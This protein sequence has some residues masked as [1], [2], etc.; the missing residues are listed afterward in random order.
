MIESAYSLL[1]DSIHLN[2]FI[3]RKLPKKT[4]S[5][6]IENFREVKYVEIDS[7]NLVFYTTNEKNRLL[8]TELNNILD[9][10]RKKN[11]S[12]FINLLIEKFPTQ[13][14]DSIIYKVIFRN[15]IL[16]LS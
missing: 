3:N 15:R 4:N 14:A 16:L 5:L 8:A 9:T 7:T 2:K 13:N 6:D 10:I 11:K 1:S 12:S